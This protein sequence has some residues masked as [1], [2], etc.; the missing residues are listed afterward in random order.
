MT[1]GIDI[2][3]KHNIEK[4]G[5]KAKLAIDLKNKVRF[6]IDE[7][8]ER[9]VKIYT[10]GIGEPGRFE[11][12][13]SVLVLDHSGSMTPPADNVDTTSK[14]EALH[15]AAQRYCESMSKEGRVAIIPFSSQVTTV[16]EFR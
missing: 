11:K 13:N 12:V 2:N 8:K 3:S 6:L 5:D 9:R 14:I 4:P 10:I 16:W 15:E 1:Y 7:A